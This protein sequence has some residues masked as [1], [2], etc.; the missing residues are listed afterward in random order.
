MALTR[1]YFPASLVPMWRRRVFAI[2]L[3]YGPDHSAEGM[4]V[5]RQQMQR[6]FQ[7]GRASYLVV[8]NALDVSAPFQV[9]GDVTRLPGDNSNREFSGWDRGLQWLRSSCAISPNDIVVLANDTFHRSYGTDYLDLFHPKDV[10]RALRSN[11]LIGYMDA[12]P[13]PVTL[14]SHRLRS[15]V[16]SS[17]V[18]STARTVFRLTPLQIGD[19]DDLVFSRA[20]N[21]FFRPDA[22]LSER[23]RE[24]VQTW[25]FGEEPAEGFREAWHSQAQL[26]EANRDAMRA[27]AKCIFAEHALS[28]KAR[29]LPVK[30]VDV[31]GVSYDL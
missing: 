9:E 11:A 3:Q 12:Y 23:Y 21:Q 6:L 18:I 8:D 27:K 20:P 25:L 16:R 17:F 2:F 30:L 31:R 5:L 15:W 26:T 19:V 13:E 22:P 7:G 4:K 14:F 28:A 1:S 10:A 29:E 24:Y